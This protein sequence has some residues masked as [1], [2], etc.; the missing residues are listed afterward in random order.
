MLDWKS[1]TTD[2]AAGVGI[3]NWALASGSLTLLSVAMMWMFIR[4]ISRRPHK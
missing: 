3:Q 2:V 1:L 4:V